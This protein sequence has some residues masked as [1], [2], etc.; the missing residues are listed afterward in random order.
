[1]LYL[2]VI[3]QHTKLK[4]VFS[5]IFSTKPYLRIEYSCIAVLHINE[6]LYKSELI[7]ST[8]HYHTSKYTSENICKKNLYKIYV[9][10]IKYLLPSTST[11]FSSPTSN[12]EFVIYNINTFVLEAGFTIGIIW[13]HKII[14]YFLL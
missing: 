2:L 8:F 3:I 14:L 11:P 5:F 12:Y 1:M 9:I 4:F 13:L 10:S 7:D 6:Y